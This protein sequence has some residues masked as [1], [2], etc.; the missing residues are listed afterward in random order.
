[1]FPKQLGRREEIVGAVLLLEVLA[2][3]I[4]GVPCRVEQIVAAIDLRRDYM[5]PAGARLRPS[6]PAIVTG[7]AG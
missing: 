3:D 4:A 2:G 5:E 1:M 7:A 6:A